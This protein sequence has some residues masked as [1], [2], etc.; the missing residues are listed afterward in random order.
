MME[1]EEGRHREDWEIRACAAVWRLLYVLTKD[2]KE[3]TGWRRVMCFL[4]GQAE[5][6]KLTGPPKREIFHKQMKISSGYKR[7]SE[8]VLF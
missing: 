2:S 3:G 7:R 5:F 6:D 4:S 1:G 8:I